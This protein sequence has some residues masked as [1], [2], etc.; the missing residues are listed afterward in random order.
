MRGQISRS[1]EA[2]LVVLQITTAPK[3]PRAL[4]V[5]ESIEQVV[6]LAKYHL[7]NNVYPQFDFVYRME[8]KGQTHLEI[9]LNIF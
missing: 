7:E 5:Q 3:I 9:V 8:Y 1:C 4:V 6:S 2:S